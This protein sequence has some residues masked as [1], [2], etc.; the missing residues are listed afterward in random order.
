VFNDFVRIRQALSQEMAYEI[1]LCTQVQLGFAVPRVSFA[2]NMLT[3]VVARDLFR[4]LAS[5]ANAGGLT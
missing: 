1:D 5:G 4:M 2:T 3:V